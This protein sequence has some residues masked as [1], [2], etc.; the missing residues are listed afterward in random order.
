M[1]HAIKII[2]ILIIEL[3]FYFCLGCTMNKVKFLPKMSLVTGNFVQGFLGYHF[4]FFCIAFPCTFL[5]RSLNF[6][7]ICWLVFICTLII[8][9]YFWNR[10]GI[11][12]AYVEMLCNAR[13]YKYL[14]LPCLA[15]VV[16]LIYYVSVNGQSDIDARTYI[17]T[18]TTMVDTNR[19][20]GI[21]P[22]T[23]RELDFIALKRSFSMFEA[24]S[25]VLC[26][27]F[28]IHPLIFCR[29][30][31]ASINIILLSAV[32]FEIFKWVYRRYVAQIEHAT[33]TL[34]LALSG[35]FLFRNSIYTSSAFILYRA[36]EGK[37]YCSGVL[38]LISLYL[39][40][41]CCKTRDRRFFVLIFIGMTAGMSIS[42]SATFILPAAVGSIVGAHIL[43]KRK[44][45]YLVPLFFSLM[46][47]ILY[48]I[49]YL[50]GFA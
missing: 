19:L 42:P 47:N 37:A 28:R 46:P 29:T 5:N 11:K 3:N 10:R 18:V 30:V 8:S 48:A 41:L 25:A 7:T 15:L 50:V 38:V 20:A 32:S 17:G 33:M 39:A 36:Y 9:I 1:L 23:G 40:F 4:L 12:H 13:E 44:W 26:K 49:A 2:F 14:L 24:N 16:F 34:M 35:L 45:N 6:L 43:V 27:V 31:R 22:T 21:Q